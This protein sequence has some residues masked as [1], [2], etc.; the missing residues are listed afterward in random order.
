MHVSKHWTGF[1]TEMW[2]WNMGMDYRTGMWDC[3]MELNSALTPEPMSAYQATLNKGRKNVKQS[4]ASLR[5]VF[6][7]I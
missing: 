2:D 4:E 6:S 5:W 3:N 1:S 7:V